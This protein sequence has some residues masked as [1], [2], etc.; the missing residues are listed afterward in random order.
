MPTVPRYGGE[1]IQTQ[2]MPNAR[3]TTE[4][5][6]SAFGGGQSLE[7]LTHAARQY[8]ATETA[9]YRDE[10]RKADDLA[11][12]EAW[13]QLA[14]KKQA[15]MWGDS[16][17]MTR[18]GKDA[19][20][21]PDEF[22]G[23]FTKAADEI[24]AG[25]ANEDQKALFRK[26]RDREEVEFQ[27]HLQKH[28]FTERQAYDNEVVKTGLG[29]ARDEAVLN[30]QDAGKVQQ[31]I[32]TQA[33]L[34]NSFAERN[35]K[36]AAWVQ[37]Q[38][39]DAVS[40][41]HASVAM[42]MLTNGEDLKA[43][44]YFEENKAAFGGEDVVHLEKA[45]EEGSIRG[46]SQRQSDA[47]ISKYGSLQA[48]VTEVKKIED[49]KLRDATMD[50]V[51][52]EFQL[53]EAAKRDAE[54][55]D[56]LSATNIIEKG[57]SYDQIPPAMIARMPLSHRSALRN[58]ATGKDHET[59]LKTYYDLK[60][61]AA[62][63]A[64]RDQFLKTNLLDYADKFSKS[65]LKEMMNL[66]AGLRT[67]DGKAEKALDG[68][69]SDSQIVTNTLQEAGI[70]DEEQKALFMRKADEQAALF[71]KQ[72][73][74]KPTNEEMQTITDRLMMKVVTDRGF[75]WD[76]K[77]RAFEL[78]PEDKPEAN[79]EDIPKADRDLIATA[80]RRKG[81]RNVTNDM[82]IQVFNQSLKK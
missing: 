78:K 75:L 43:K 24:E 27:G 40:K 30:Y 22:G 35:G 23:Q 46:E 3:I 52:G 72:S 60:T 19:F 73:G 54:E 55:K 21:V 80:L 81:V 28:V 11:T 63:P 67:N 7:N 38:V 37:Q 15:M 42:R 79:F 13:K 61:Q 44:K 77:K 53:R 33:A 45:L 41:T 12:T 18:K 36:D 50:R 68:F 64:L 70:K 14:E 49:P 82:I 65:D 8:A 71:A 32:G 9:I 16:G 51:R 5:P 4:A 10:K 47:I 6:L 69:R 48:A 39:A 58:Y 1:Q 62:T 76:S 25:L 57:G 20:G 74:R 56:F 66:Q 31:A 59:D 34:I 2:A 29:V 17:A 26:I